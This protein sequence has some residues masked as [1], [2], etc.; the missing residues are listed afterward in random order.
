VR[1]RVQKRLAGT[2]FSTVCSHRPYGAGNGHTECRCPQARNTR[3]DDNGP[4]TDDH[5]HRRGLFDRERPQPEI[6]NKG[7]GGRRDVF[8]CG[9]GCGHHTLLDLSGLVAWELYLT[10]RA[11]R[12]NNRGIAEP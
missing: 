10:H 2:F 5:G 7:C 1:H 9:V 4:D 11:L 3:S 12:F 8:G 6:G